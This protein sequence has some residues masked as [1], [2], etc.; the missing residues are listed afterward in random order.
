MTCKRLRSMPLTVGL[1]VM[2]AC[3]DEATSPV[4]P[5]ASSTAT[6]ALAAASAALSFRQVSTSSSHSCG[7][8]TSDVAYCWGSNDIGELGTG[9]TT[10][11]E[12]CGLI[13]PCSTRPVAVTGGL[14]FRQVSAGF[15]H[16]CGVTTNNLAYCWGNGEG[17]EGNFSARPVAVPGTRRFLQVTAG[18]SHGC[19]VTPLSKA[20]CWGRFGGGVLGD[21]TFSGRLTPVAVASGLLFAEVRAGGS[22]T[23]G[24]TTDNRAYCWGEN[25]EGQLGDGTKT[26]RT[27][28]VPVLGGISF[29]NVSA[30]L[31]H[32]CGVSASS[33]AYCGAETMASLV[34]ARMSPAG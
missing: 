18:T 13:N 22:H 1:L 26:W 19:G 33:K 3:R 30:G 25:R 4:S 9:S 14:N 17:P 32:S 27:K 6:P 20:V 24:R 31:F 15:R 11:P 10:G 16:S 2:V 7:V 29:R 8:T 28:P 34:S 5:E 12:T 21:G 23:C